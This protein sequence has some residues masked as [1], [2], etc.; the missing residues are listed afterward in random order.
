VSTADSGDYGFGRRSWR[1]SR[2]RGHFGR[3]LCAGWCAVQ[4]IRHRPASIDSGATKRRPGLPT[5]GLRG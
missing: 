5:T 2:R 4:C 3:Y 1:S